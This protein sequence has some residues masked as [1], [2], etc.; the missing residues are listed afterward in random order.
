VESKGKFNKPV[1]FALLDPAQNIKVEFLLYPKGDG[2]PN[3]SLH[4]Y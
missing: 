1:K 2:D 4:L 3:R